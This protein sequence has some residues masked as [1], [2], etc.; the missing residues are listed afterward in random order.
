MV[1][2]PFDIIVHVDNVGGTP[3]QARAGWTRVYWRRG[4]FGE[5]LLPVTPGTSAGYAFDE[6]AIRIVPSR[7][8]TYYY[9]VQIEDEQGRRSNVLAGKMWIPARWRESCGES[10]SPGGSS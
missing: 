7:S 4:G 6:V 3:K 8:G 2:C 1:G 5:E 10:N 9:S